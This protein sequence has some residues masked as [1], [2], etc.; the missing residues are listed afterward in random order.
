MKRK[1]KWIASS[2]L[3]AS[4]LGVAIIN[5]A[6]GNQTQTQAETTI[7]STKAAT[8]KN[9]TLKEMLT[10]A[11]QDEYMAQAEYDA[12]MDKYGVQKPFSNII[13]SEATHIDLLLPLFKTYDVAVPKND[14]ANRVVVPDSLEKSYAAGV[15]AEEKNIAMYESFLKEDVPDNV[16]EVF[17]KL[18]AASENHLAAF[19]RAED[20]KMGQGQGMGKGNGKGNGKNGQHSGMGMNHSGSN[21]TGNGMGNGNTED[22]QMQ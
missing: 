14:A 21:G 4:V 7:G 8:D 9:Y 15:E 3:I 12:I 22:C 11:I 1:Y 19:E 18:L 6:T 2:L 16:K 13:Q 10:Y 20:G 5:D 17:E